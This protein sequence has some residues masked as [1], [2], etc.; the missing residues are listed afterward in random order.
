MGI[1][2]TGAASW[3]SLTGWSERRDSNGRL[4]SSRVWDG[5]SSSYTYGSSSSDSKTLVM[6]AFRN[7]AWDASFTISSFTT[8]PVA[9]SFTIGA[10]NS[11]LVGLATNPE[12]S[13]EWTAPSGWTKIFSATSPNSISIWKDNNLRASGSSGT[14]T[15]TR[16]AGTLTGRA[17]Q[18][19]V[20]P[21]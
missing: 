9:S 1:H 4:I 19:S 18:F 10:S 14:T 3:N 16:T 17:Q 11:I 5:V 12:A 6:L 20:S 7:F 15:F 13:Q 2:G 21:T 8:N